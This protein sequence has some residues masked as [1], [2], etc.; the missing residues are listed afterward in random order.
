MI[1][2]RNRTIHEIPTTT[3]V[4]EMDHVDDQLDA[5][6]MTPDVS[7]AIPLAEDGNQLDSLTDIVEVHDKFV[8]KTLSGNDGKAAM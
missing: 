6:D 1:D 2:H 7:C 3:V 4:V 8:G 5:P